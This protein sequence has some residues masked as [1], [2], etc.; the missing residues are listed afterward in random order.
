MQTFKGHIATECNTIQSDTIQYNKT[1]CFICDADLR[2]ITHKQKSMMY[3]QQQEYTSVK[4]RT[5]QV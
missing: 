5:M 3:V 1:Q 2:L 4:E